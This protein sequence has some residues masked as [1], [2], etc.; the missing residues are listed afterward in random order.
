MTVGVEPRIVVGDVTEEWGREE[1]DGTE[2]YPD[3]SAYVCVRVYIGQQVHRVG[4]V[5]GIYQSDHGSALAS[6]LGAGY[7]GVR[8]PAV[9]WSTASDHQDLPDYLVQP[10]LD[11][12][13]GASRRLWRDALDARP[14][15]E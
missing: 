3:L 2:S 12:L 1:D 4:C 5:I 11:A 10:V 14:Q 15:A 7:Y 9:W 13:A 6:G 8:G